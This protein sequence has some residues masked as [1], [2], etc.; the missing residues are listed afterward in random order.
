MPFWGKVTGEREV[1]S[2]F[3][4]GT[5]M[6]GGLALWIMPDFWL[7]LAGPALIIVGLLSLLDD[8]FPYG[9]QPYL[10]SELGGFFA[11]FIVAAISSIFVAGTILWLLAVVFVITIIKMSLRVAKKIL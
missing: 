8:V 3:L 1:V 2:G 10:M 11:G 9:R 6:T 5:L 4:P 7:S